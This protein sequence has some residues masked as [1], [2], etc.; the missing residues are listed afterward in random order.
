V[1]VT[2]KKHGPRSP[3]WH[4][5]PRQYQLEAQQRFAIAKDRGVLP[6]SYVTTDCDVPQ[7]LDVECMTLH[8]AKRIE[9]PR[10]IC[11]Y[12]GEG[13]YTRD[14]LM[15]EPMTGLAVRTMVAVVPACRSCNSAIGDLPS[16]NVAERRRRAQ[17]SIERRNK[18]ILLR[19][20]KT[21]AD[22]A[23][24]GPTMRS[25]AE[26]NNTLHDR[27]KARLAWP[28]DPHYDLRAFQRSGIEDPES[29]GLCELT[30]KPLRPEYQ[31]AA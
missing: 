23:E 8:A 25:V 27:V 21:A 11:V 31:E 10:D 22:L 15:P 4:G 1:R 28:L 24:L 5:N 2:G 12:C 18:K 7:C 6:W 13:G 9:Y 30:S 3:R 29:L 16:W 17:L 26:K 19:P 14:H 20:R